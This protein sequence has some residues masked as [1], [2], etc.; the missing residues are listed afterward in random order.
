[1][2]ALALTY[3]SSGLMLIRGPGFATTCYIIRNLF[4]LNIIIVPL[5]AFPIRFP[6][7]FQPFDGNEESF[8]QSPPPPQ[9]SY[10]NEEQPF[11]QPP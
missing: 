7:P 9:V 1:M 3:P 6:F 5:S 4:V 2:Y 8:S 10:G 11:I